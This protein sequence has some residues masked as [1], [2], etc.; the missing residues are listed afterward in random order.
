MDLPKVFLQLPRDGISFKAGARL[1]AGS[2]I[3]RQEAGKW[4][5]WG[6]GGVVTSTQ[7]SVNPLL[8]VGNPEV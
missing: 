2:Q 5:G 1:G 3:T 7:S 8:Q 4:R 6:A